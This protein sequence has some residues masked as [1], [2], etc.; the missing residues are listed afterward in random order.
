MCVEAESAAAGARWGPEGPSLWQ[1]A[2][3]EANYKAVG[4]QENSLCPR[5][6]PVPIAVQQHQGHAIG[7]AKPLLEKGKVRGASSQDL[8]RVEGSPPRGPAPGVPGSASRAP[9]WD[10]TSMEEAEAQRG[11]VMASYGDS[12]APK[13]P[14]GCGPLT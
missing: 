12:R 14:G 11:E 5:V 4:L 7:P 8:L 2:E 3:Q 1:E 6:Q 9:P 10:L 13:L